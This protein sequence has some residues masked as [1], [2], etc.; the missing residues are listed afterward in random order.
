MKKTRLYNRIVSLLLLSLI[1]MASL[2]AC[3]NSSTD[4]TEPSDTTPEVKYNVGIIR[5]EISE[6]SE[7]ALE[8]F[9]RAFSEK[10]F[11]ADVT[12]SSTVIDCNGKK[13]ECE[14]AAEQFVSDDVN[15]IF[16]I[17]EKAAKAA[18]KATKTIPIIFCGV[19][20]PIESKLLKSCSE[21]EGNITGVTDYTPVYDQIE[22]IK[23]LLP[24]SKKIS[25]LYNT[26]DEGSILVS[27]LASAEAEMLKMEYSPYTASSKEQLKN[28]L[29][30]A[31]KDT[32][33][34]YI[35]DDDFIR[36]N[37]ETI[38]KTANKKN[39]PVFCVNEELL[40]DGCLATSLPDY[41]DLGYNAGELALICLKE[42]HPISSIAVEYPTVCI[43]YI[44][45]SVAQKYSIDISG[46]EDFQ[47][48]N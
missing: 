28:V 22:L 31:L 42:L 12:Y 32:D 37:I 45:K 29:S 2:C 16:A 47:F 7:K 26:T 34:L 48:V 24:D 43:D 1:I 21:P 3:S 13:A 20:D 33:A 36:E 19:A 25:A 35:P 27:T 46:Y 39:V 10:N 44:N 4:N 40:A 38:I 5:T 11:E 23:E 6:E 41:E 14:A 15:L 30:D 17:G 18:K 9:Y 8:G